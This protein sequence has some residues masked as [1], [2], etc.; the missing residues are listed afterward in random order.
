MVFDPKHI[1]IAREALTLAS[2]YLLVGTLT[3]DEDDSHSL[4]VPRD[5]CYIA[6]IC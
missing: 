1:T 3:V 5:Q 2:P 6:Q 4:A